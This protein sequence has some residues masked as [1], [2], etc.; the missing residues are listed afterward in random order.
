MYSFMS[1]SSKNLSKYFLGL[2]EIDSIPLAYLNTAASI[3]PAE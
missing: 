1:A 3:Y 2:L